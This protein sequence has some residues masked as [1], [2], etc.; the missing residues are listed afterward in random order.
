MKKGQS[1]LPD[2]VRWENGRL[3]I[4]DQSELP[5]KV[6]YKELTCLD[7][8]WEAIRQLEVR[9]APAIGI[10]VGYGICLATLN[11]KAD[12]YEELWA[13]FQKNAAYLAS[14]RPTA[15]NLF[16]ALDRMSNKVKR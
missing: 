11:S 6:V 3:V 15:V 12:S 16:W 10:T 2:S 4:L 1:H 8:V 14:S 9:G 13:E 5:I 7:E